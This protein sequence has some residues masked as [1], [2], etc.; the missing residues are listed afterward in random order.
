MTGVFTDELTREK[1]RFLCLE[2][3]T[4][5]SH[6][7]NQNTLFLFQLRENEWTDIGSILTTVFT[8]A[9]ELTIQTQA[10]DLL[11]A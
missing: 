2:K 5:P 7:L 8:A 1:L 11:K 9:S 3:R 4:V 6:Y 10:R